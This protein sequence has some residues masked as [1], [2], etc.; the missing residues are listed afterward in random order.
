MDKHQI[1]ALLRELK[2]VF[3][4]DRWFDLGQRL[5][6]NWDRIPSAQWIAGCNHEMEHIETVGG[7]RLTIARIALDHLR[8]DP[9]YYQ[10]L[11]GIEKS[12]SRRS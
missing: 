8:E 9:N 12:V 3:A 2:A 1:K 5:G 4:D 10:K 6:V 11:K 7:N